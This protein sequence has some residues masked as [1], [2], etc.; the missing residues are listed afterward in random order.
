[1]TAHDTAVRELETTG[2]TV[3]DHR[4]DPPVLAALRTAFNCYFDHV[5]AQ[6]DPR[7]A[8]RSGTER[9]NVRLPLHG[10]FLAPEI[11]TDPVVLS[12]LR[13][14]LDDD[15]TCTYFAS[16]TAMPGA[17]FQAVHPDETP[18]FPGLPLTLPP[19]SYVLN[20]PLVDFRLDNGPLEI[21]PQGTHLMR[22]TGVIP[23]EPA[24]AG[25]EV[26]RQPNQRLAEAMRSQPLLLS[27]GSLLLRD[28]RVWHRGTPNRSTQRRSMVALVYSRPWHVSHTLPVARSTYQS[29]DHTA[30]LL[31]RN[32]HLCD[33]EV[34]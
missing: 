33:H 21:W 19:H 24:A 3:Q 31:F 2:F 28:T 12:V 16:D 4:L 10:I 5:V 32:V 11:V 15:I 13:S 1:M 14:L 17:D 34:A 22:D 27:A 30:R 9:Y 20:I 29:L 25:P 18:L 7:R 26:R 8:R 6:G 23:K